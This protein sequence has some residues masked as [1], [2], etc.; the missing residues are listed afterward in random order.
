M[1]IHDAHNWIDVDS[2]Y[3]V[4]YRWYSR[5][6]PYKKTGL[7]IATILI[8]H[9]K[10]KSTPTDDNTRSI[11]PNYSSQGKGNIRNILV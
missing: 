11:Q 2:R 5:L 4:G 8:K 3:L 6:S 9:I 10:R 1:R 7:N